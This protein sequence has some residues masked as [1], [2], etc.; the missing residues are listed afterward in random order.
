MSA[1]YRKSVASCNG[2]LVWIPRTLDALLSRRV[3]LTP[4]RRSSGTFR[5][6]P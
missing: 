6:R 4:S 5:H 3:A 1:R 2:D